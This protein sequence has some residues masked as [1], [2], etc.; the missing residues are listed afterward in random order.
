MSDR[1]PLALVHDYLTQQGGAERVVL[2]LAEAYPD[3]A[4][5]TSFYDSDAT[6]PG[7]RAHEIRTMA[8][9]RVGPFRHHHRLALPVLAPAFSR[10]RVDAEV[11]ICSSSGWAHGA[12]VTG[13][14]I[15][16][17]HTPA[18]WLYQTDRYL[19]G[20]GHGSA[21]VMGILGPPLRRWDRRAA[22]T[23]DRYVV[24]SHAVR[25]R[26]AEL[27]GTH[28]TVVPPP[29]DFPVK[30]DERPVP[31]IEAG[32]VLCVSRLLPYKNVESVTAAF[33]RLPDRRL[34]VVGAGP[35]AGQL[36]A[37]ASGNVT[38]LGGVDDPTLRWLYRSCAGLVAASYE[39]FGLTPVEAA[40]FGKPTAALRFGG[41]LDTLVEDRTG[42]FFD[43]PDPD[44]IAG[45]LERLLGRAWDAAAL[46][47]HA[48]RFSRER[49][50]TRMDR[51]VAEERTRR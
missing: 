28:A 45:S 17:C 41:Y 23:V 29:V 3:A 19:A 33:G 25:H 14:K 13:R 36:A 44:A 31:G 4:V 40:G 46:A 37:D 42:V 32:F 51:I 38:L 15:V 49:F 35:L 2:A 11:A 21:A 1:P 34:V 27:Y 9:D 5:Y 43:S 16:Y 48:A 26:V 18:R 6:F 24:N 39:D 12:R 22:A 47:A 7:F 10:F 8:L 20:R 30:G 50:L